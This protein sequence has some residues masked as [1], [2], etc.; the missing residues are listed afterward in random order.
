[1]KSL[2]SFKGIISMLFIALLL[3]FIFLKVQN[4]MTVT[5]VTNCKVL[6]LQQQQIIKKTTTDI[7]Y[8]VITDKETFVVKNSLINGKFN[9]SDVFFRLKKGAYYTFMVS[10]KGKSF[11]FD[12]K[13]ILEA[14]QV[15][16]KINQ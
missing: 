7:R 15:T 10:G 8:L 4:S 14:Q 3:T 2:L 5:S 11:L 12:Y 1:M 9:N 13:N 16:G 6:D